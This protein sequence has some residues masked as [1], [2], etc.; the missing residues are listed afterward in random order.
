MKRAIGHR[1][2]RPFHRWRRPAWSSMVTW[3]Q[4]FH[5]RMPRGRQGFC[6]KPGSVKTAVGPFAAVR[7]RSEKRAV[8]ARMRPEGGTR[9]THCEGRCDRTG[10]R[11]TAS[12]RCAL[13]RGEDDADT[14][15]TQSNSSTEIP[16][17]KQ[18]D[19]FSAQIENADVQVSRTRSQAGPKRLANPP[20]NKTNVQSGRQLNSAAQ[21]TSST[22]FTLRCCEPSCPS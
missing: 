21:E 4:S 19:R 2:G 5:F 22:S 13:E 18:A 17:R 14:T 10:I 16:G 8:C 7:G 12:R 6:R 15:A 3:N 9:Q 1:R 20:P 11:A